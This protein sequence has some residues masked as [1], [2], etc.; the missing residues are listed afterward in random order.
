MEHSAPPRNQ[1][2]SQHTL[3]MASYAIIKTGGKQYR[4]TEG[5]KVDVEFLD[6][7]EGDSTT[8]SEVLLVNDGSEISFGTPFI[9]GATVTAEVVSQHRAKK[10][11]AFK[12]RRR[13]GYHK[14]RGH[15]RQLTRLAIKSISL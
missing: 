1:Q 9:E 4:V 10:V 14:T 11:V 5:D 3:Q 2:F 13:K 8:L 15:R 7:A 6:L 12:F